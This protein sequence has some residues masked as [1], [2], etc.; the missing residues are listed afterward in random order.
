MIQF[1]DLHKELLVAPLSYNS[2]YKQ[3]LK[4]QDQLSEKHLFKKEG[5]CSPQRND[6]FQTWENWP[7]GN[8]S[9]A[10][11]GPILRLLLCC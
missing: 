10:C 11:C 6:A 1:K 8:D 2:G 5:A 4:Q 3:W 9:A 7:D